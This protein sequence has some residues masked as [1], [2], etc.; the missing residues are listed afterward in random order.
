MSVYRLSERSGGVIGTIGPIAGSGVFSLQERYA[1]TAD[2]YENVSLYLKMNGANGSTTFYD[3]SL[4][5]FTVTAN[6]NAQISTAQSK[7]GGASAAFDGTGDYLTVPSK[8]NELHGKTTDYTIECWIYAASTAGRKCILETGA[9]SASS[10]VLLELNSGVVKYNIYRSVFGS[11]TTAT[12]A[13]AISTG[14]WYHVAVSVTTSDIKVFIN[15][16]EESSVAWS[17][18]G[19][20]SDSQVNL[21]IGDDNISVVTGFVGYID[22]L[23]ITKGLAGARYTGNF[24]PPQREFRP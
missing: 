17:L 22:D 20:A 6:G 10:G 23:R 9:A 19:S 3:S 5:N 7:F 12:T 11:F 13:T 14:V 15:G 18:D 4:N 24:T 16:T 2:N 8:F 1:L 21:T